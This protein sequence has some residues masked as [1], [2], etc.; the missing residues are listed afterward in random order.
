MPWGASMCSLLISVLNSRR[1]KSGVGFRGFTSWV[2]R[3]CFWWYLSLGSKL[4]DHGRTGEGSAPAPPSV[5]VPRPVA[6]GLASRRQVRMQLLAAFTHG[7]PNPQR[8]VCAMRVSNHHVK[9]SS[10][11]FCVCIISLWPRRCRCVNV[12]EYVLASC[13]A[14]RML[15]QVL[16]ALCAQRRLLLKPLIKNYFS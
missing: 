10:H 2:W 7:A 4:E 8:I 5:P 1:R 6:R 13:A 3:S 16:V 12:L 9:K 15:Q 14:L 11:L